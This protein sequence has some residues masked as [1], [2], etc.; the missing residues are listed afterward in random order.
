MNVLKRNS[1]GA[2]IRNAVTGALCSTCRA[3]YREYIELDGVR[4]I[5]VGAIPDEVFSYSIRNRFASYDPDDFFVYYWIVL[6][7]R[8]KATNLRVWTESYYWRHEGW[9]DYAD[10]VYVVFGN[11]ADGAP[12]Q[13]VVGHSWG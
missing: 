8:E 12:A 7:C 9:V 2:L 1:N 13:I 5:G 10:G 6:E 3:R 4:R 11:P